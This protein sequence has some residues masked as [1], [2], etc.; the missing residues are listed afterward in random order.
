MQLSASNIS[1]DAAATVREMIVT[2]RLADGD[3]INEVHLA[4]QLD[5][6][7]T[8]LREGLWRLASEGVITTVPRKGFFV[9]PLTLSEFE[10]LYDIRPILDPEALRLAGIPSPAA[11]D[12]LEKLNRKFVAAKKPSEAIEIDNA[13]HMALLAG[14]PNRVLVDMIAQI[15]GRTRRYEHA[16]FRETENIWSASDEHA[17]ILAAL[18]DGD[19][20]RACAMLK[21]NM[22]SGKAPIVE[23]LTRRTNATDGPD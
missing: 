3:R 8:P 1:Q 17:L 19:L 13:W 23:W 6:S 18:R 16:L 15:I 7:R 4:A 20:K 12:R 2:G 5:V 10:Q 11:L 14:C 22:Q 9:A 21:R